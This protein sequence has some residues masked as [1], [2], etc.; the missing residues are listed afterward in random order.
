MQNE[1]NQYYIGLLREKY[2]K[3]TKSEKTRYL[4]EAETFTKLSRKRIIK[5]LNEKLKRDRTGFS[6]GRPL[7]DNGLGIEDAA[8]EKVFMIFQRVRPHS[9]VEGTGIGLAMAKKI[10]ERHG[11]TISVQSEDGVGSTFIFTFPSAEC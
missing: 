1:L 6:R 3:A 11:G 4:D 9:G 8:Q 7:Q 2:S 5:K 10:V